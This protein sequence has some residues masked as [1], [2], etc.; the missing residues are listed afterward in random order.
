MV[1]FNKLIFRSIPPFL[2]QNV[3]EDELDGSIDFRMNLLPGEGR[4]RMEIYLTAAKRARIMNQVD[5]W[6]LRNVDKFILMV[7]TGDRHEARI[8]DRLSI[9]SEIFCH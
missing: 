2:Q 9:R 5:E 6:C 1:K 8:T 4:F 7:G 3:E